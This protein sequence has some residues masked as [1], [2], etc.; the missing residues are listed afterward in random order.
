MDPKIEIHRYDHRFFNRIFEIHKV[1]FPDDEVTS[2]GLMEEILAPSRRYFV[3][4]IDGKVVGYIGAWNTKSDYSIITV[5]VDPDSRGMGIAKRMIEALK[6]DAKSNEIYAISLE[7]NEDNIP[8]MCLYRQ[9]GFIITNTRKN[10]YKGGKSAHIM[11]L[12]M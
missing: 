11:W 8:A 3:A 4:T 2:M 1:C 10:Y 6:D 7:V 5:A 9:A 12:Y